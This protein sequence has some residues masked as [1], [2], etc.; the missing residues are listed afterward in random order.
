MEKVD[1]YAAR[2]TSL[3]F[4]SLRCTSHSTWSFMEDFVSQ[5]C[6][7]MDAGVL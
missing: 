1:V 5:I 3:N 2:V 7:P 6:R 4:V